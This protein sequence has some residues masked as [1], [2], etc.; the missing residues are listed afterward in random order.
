ML[1]SPEIQF[2]EQQI[3][4]YYK[5]NYKNKI[6]NEVDFESTL[7]LPFNKSY[8][9]YKKSNCCI[10][11][12]S[13]LVY[14]IF[15]LIIA[16]AG[17][18]FALSENKGYK[19]YKGVLERN[20]SLIDNEFPHEYETI[21]LV[22]YLT[23]DK[24]NSEC[25]Y[26]EYSLQKCSLASYRRFCTP[27]LYS[28][29]KCNYMDRE[30]FLGYTFTCNLANYEN[31]LC[32]QVQYID[33]LESI[34]GK[35]Y[36]SKISYIPD[37]QI[38]L[39]SFT[40]EEMWC[41][42]GDYD[43]P[44]FLSFI[45]LLGIFII[46]LIFD[47][48]TKKSTLISGA[49]YYFIIIFYMIYYI[50][51]R[52]YALLF[53]MLTS[54]GIIICFNYPTTEYEE[55]GDPVG[56]PFFE[57]RE[58][59]FPEEQTWKDEKLYAFIF[60]GICLIL[61]I[62]V[63][64]LS[65][66]K[67]LIFNYLCFNFNNEIEENNMEKN[68]PEILRNASIQIANV[69]YNFQI[70]QNK[71]LYLNE[72]RTSKKYSFKEVLLQN[73][74]Y[75]LKCNN[76]GLYDQ[77]SW[78]QFKFPDKNTLFIILMK[79]LNLIIL[80]FFFII[81]IRIWKIKNDAT[82]DYY[83]HLIDLGY[84]P[85]RYKYLQISEDL[86]EPFYNYILVINIILGLFV[87]ISIGKIAFFG[88]FKNIKF[89]LI[90]ILISVFFAL[91]NL[92]TTII[93]LLG[94]LY[95]ILGTSGFPNDDI[96]FQGGSLTISMILMYIFYLFV[97]F[98]SFSLFIFSLSLIFPLIQI[99]GENKKLEKENTKED[100]F[101][102][103]SFQNE[104]FILEAVNTNNSLPKHLF[105]T[106]KI[107][108]NPIINFNLPEGGD[109]IL[110]LE[111]NNEHILDDKEKGYLFNFKK[112]EFNTEKRIISK[113]IAQIIYSGLIF[114]LLIVNISYSFNRN[115]YYDAYRDYLLESEKEAESEDSILDSILPS[116]AI[117]WCDLGDFENG[118]LISLLIFIIFYLIF[119]TLSLL[120]HKGVI[121][122][123]YQNGLFYQII[124]FTN[125]I[126]Y[127]LFKIYFALA[128]F[129]I[130]Y[131]LG[132]IVQSP[133]NST[134]ELDELFL[135][136][137]ENGLG[138]EWDKKKYEL[139]VN[140]VLKIIWTIFLNRLI[141]IRFIIIEYL[142]KNYEEN[143][144]ED[145]PNNKE[146]REKNEIQTSININNIEFNATIKL[147]EILYLH[148][149]GYKGKEQL[150][151]FKKI[152]IQYIT[153]QF[154]YVR[155]GKNTI[156]DIISNS[157]WNYPDFNDF[158]MKLGDMC[159]WIYVILLFS[160]P[161]FKF[162]VDKDLTYQIIKL[163]HKDYEVTNIKKPQFSN[164]FDAYESFEKGVTL[165]R[166]ILY[167]IQLFILLLLVLKRIYFGGFKK[168]INLIVIFAIDIIFL[169]QNII[170][171]ILDFILALFSI[172]SISCY[173]K[174]KYNQMN[175]TFLEAKFFLQL[176]INILIFFFNFALLRYNIDLTIEVNKLR[177]EF[178][179]F[180]RL[181]D[182][183][184]ESIPYLKP[185]EFKYVSLD[186][187]ICSIKEFKSNCTQRYLFYS[188]NIE[189]NEQIYNADKNIANDI[190][191]LIPHKPEGREIN[192]DIKN[193]DGKKL[194][195]ND[196]DANP[197]TDKNLK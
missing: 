46:F 9:K 69:T 121:K 192:E 100:C 106:K 95:S 147:N 104:Q 22:N 52:I 117:F 153:P 140:I 125:I 112:N 187:N 94:A 126:F 101:K 31:G 182:N 5:Q 161:L 167:V 111:S 154:V 21:K 6:C 23:R 188:T 54:Y 110:C 177:K 25:S 79:M 42:I 26:I 96:E 41:K 166:F 162:H 122:I 12:T 173:Y 197:E 83:I 102:Y 99:K 148:K 185:I 28:E 14:S 196:F 16:C 56:D 163:I 181:E 97:C 142:N 114:I 145:E 129:L 64:I 59:Y 150:F 43:R 115:I 68:K 170:Y 90:G 155:L 24:E 119:E 172:F 107:N 72:D 149:I 4:D 130:F 7:E 15:I 136:D 20:M 87:I 34:Q 77:L 164:I 61:F 160:I 191:I 152:F 165:S 151:K 48:A 138:D 13:L 189:G 29:K 66:Y 186:G 139:I 131:S 65:F 82:F 49:K 183:I 36:V 157:Q 184:D 133:Q 159:D 73:E 50:I 11:P 33:Y 179:K 127:I 18:Y 195:E 89:T 70:K 137:I 53:L 194:N 113:F 51:F 10:K 103:V 37:I 58:I 19:A 158:F 174:N 76:L 132:V 3:L 84:E 60:C 134:N 171:I 55:V 146:N 75:F 193:T 88:G 178:D 91:I 98:L 80:I 176:F 78:S 168:K 175:D 17:F 116:F 62:M 35:T 135:I 144:E 123:D 45:I 71:D 180:I 118:I 38:N 47:L 190:Q 1:S 27:T 2:S 57:S 39:T 128:I 63:L 32:N 67:K 8:K 156:T 109:V 86:N 124:V 143:E 85:K 44:I 74:T 81:Y 120:I 92:S 169:I 40:F 30:Y 141:K 93:S 108:Q 105:Y